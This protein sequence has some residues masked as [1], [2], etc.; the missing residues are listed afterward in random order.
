MLIKAM[1][2]SRSMRMLVARSYAGG[3]GC[4]LRERSGLG[5]HR[6]AVSRSCRIER[7][8]RSPSLYGAIPM[9]APEASSS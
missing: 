7:S 5:P 3:I 2:Q 8:D 9:L 1:L 4:D 6:A